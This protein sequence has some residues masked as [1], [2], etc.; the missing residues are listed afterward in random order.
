MQKKKLLIDGDILIYKIA[1]QNEIDTHWGDG[2]WT[3]HCDE[4]LCKA[5]VDA[6]IEDLGAQLEADDYIVALTDSQNFRKDVLPTYKANRKDK[7]KPM[8]LNALRKYV[9][10]K[11]NGVIWKNLEADDVLGIMAT[12]PSD[13]KRIIVSIDKDLKQIPALI[14][15]D[16]LVVNE[17]PLKLADYWF[18]IQTLSG[19]AVDG[20]TGLPTVGIKTAE[21]LIN[22]Y[23]MVPVL[24]LWKIVVGLY[25]E[26]GF[27]EQEAL[28][29]AR[30]ARILRH[31][32]YNK[33]TG[34]VKLWMT[35]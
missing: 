6:Q 34:E 31:G 27:S 35:K 15:V 33:E 4:K 14:S 24:D 2:L 10:E 3:L 9:M 17:T 29:Q 28:Q 11:H 21:K 20:Y 18:M 26:K 13:E 23:T 30:V 12:E 22:K 19:D 25:K 8:V 16:G 1:T 5:D 7:R 32:E